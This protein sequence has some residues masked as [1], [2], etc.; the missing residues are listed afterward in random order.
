MIFV[1]LAAQ[2]YDQ[3]LNMILGEVE[4]T[5]TTVELD[6]ETFEEIYKVCFNH[7]QLRDVISL[8]TIAIFLFHLDNKAKY[9]DAVCARRWSH[10]D[11]P[12]AQSGHVASDIDQNL[13]T[14]STLFSCCSHLVHV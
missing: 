10:T 1:Y 12:T 11:I 6:E 4:E 5:V 14:N 7:G 8:P 9:S 3:H 13:A 2:A